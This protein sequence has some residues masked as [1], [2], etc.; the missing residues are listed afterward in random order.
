MIKMINENIW[1]DDKIKRLSDTES[2]KTLAKIYEK[3]KQETI[4]SAI[5]CFYAGNTCFKYYIE[6]T[7][8]KHDYIWLQKLADALED[9]EVS[10]A[11]NA[12]ILMKKLE[13]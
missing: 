13:A 5:N 8:K 7:L 10:D 11:I 4:E 3:Q 12:I 2:D 9:T 1:Y 6:N